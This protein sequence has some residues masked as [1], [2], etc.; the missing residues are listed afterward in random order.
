[1]PRLLSRHPECLQLPTHR[2]HE[3]FWPEEVRVQVALG[4]QPGVQSCFG[5]QPDGVW[6]L[7]LA[8]MFVVAVEVLELTVLLG[9]LVDGFAE[10]MRFSVAGA[11]DEVNRPAG[12][13]RGF[14]HR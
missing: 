10:G 9:E 11:V 5:Q 14:E 7:L 2:C 3:G 12:A 13:Y 1:M 6:L 4:R 8:A